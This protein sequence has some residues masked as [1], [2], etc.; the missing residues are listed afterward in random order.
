MIKRRGV[1][2]SGPFGG[3]DPL[4]I[5][6]SEPLLEKFESGVLK[7]TFQCILSNHGLSSCLKENQFH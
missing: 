6:V 2:L 1:V 7:S 5:E 3:G 4:F